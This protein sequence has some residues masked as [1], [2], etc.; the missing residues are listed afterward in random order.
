[1]QSLGLVCS[2]AWRGEDRL[3]KGKEGGMLLG[4]ETWDI[5]EC[6]MMGLDA[7]E[8]QAINLGFRDVWPASWAWLRALA[9]MRGILGLW[10]TDMVK[11]PFTATT[12]PE[13]GIAGV[14]INNI[15][16]SVR[17]PGENQSI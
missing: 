9:R 10:R 11:D 15:Y 4:H 17:C 8:S 16:R 7:A 6:V 13:G 5:W 2:F 12:G 1:M 14:T 3:L